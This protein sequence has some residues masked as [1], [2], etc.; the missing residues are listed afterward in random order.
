MQGRAQALTGSGR[1]LRDEPGIDPEGGLAMP[2]AN[3]ARRRRE[4]RAG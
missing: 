1:G 3:V 2:P 4:N